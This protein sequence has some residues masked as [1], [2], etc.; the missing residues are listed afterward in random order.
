MKKVSKPEPDLA[1]QGIIWDYWKPRRTHCWNMLVLAYREIDGFEEADETEPFT[2]EYLWEN[3]FI[4]LWLFRICI[5]TLE[6]ITFVKQDA[7]H[8]IADFD[9]CF[10]I[11]NINH[12]RALRDMT[13]HWDD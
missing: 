9:S 7:T 11:E 4:R 1:K 8:I 10:I 6:K 13:E 3:F 2:L 5:L 12:L